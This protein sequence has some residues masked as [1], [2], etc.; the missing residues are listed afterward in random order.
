M[1]K[2]LNRK[3]VEQ[4]VKRQTSKDYLDEEDESMEAMAMG[5]TS[6]KASADPLEFLIEMREFD[7]LYHT[8]VAIDLGLRVGSW[9]LVKPIT[10][11][12]VCEVECQKER[13]ELCELKILA[14][15]V[16]ILSKRF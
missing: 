12:D 13:L 11:T 4:N 7:V 8:R 16:S 9:F 10:G 6:T 3:I 5:M 1:L 2:Y 15:D 14:F